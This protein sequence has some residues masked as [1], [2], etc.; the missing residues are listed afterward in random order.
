MKKLM[1]TFALMAVAALGLSACT[2]EKLVPD[3]G[4]ADGK[5]VTVHFGAE[6]AIEGATKATLTTE[7]EKTFKS[8]WE[9][10]DALS[11]EYSND[12]TPVNKGIV[13]ATWTADHFDATLPEHHGMWDYNVVYPAP[14]AESKVDFGSARTQK[15]NA[16]NSK[17]D[18]MKGSAIVENADAGKTDAGKNIVFNMTRQTAI[19]YFHLTSTL[20]EEVV[21]AKLS[22]EGGNIA[23]SL[24]MLLDHT[25]GFDL[26]TEDLNEITITFEEGTAPMASNFQLWFNVLPTAYTSMSLVVETTGHTLTLN[27]SNHGTFAAQNL[28]KVKGDVSSKW[29]EIPSVSFFYESFDSC[30]GTGGND[31]KWSGQIAT[32][33]I[34]TDNTGWTFTKENG[35]NACAKFGSG[36]KLGKATTPALGINTSSAT[37]SFKAGAWNGT[38]EVTKINIT[39]NNGGTVSPSSITLVKGQWTEYV[40]NITGATEQTTITFSASTDSKNRFFLDE[41][42]VYYGKKPFVKHVQQ[43]SFDKTSLECFVDDVTITEPK[44]S[45]AKTVVTY[46]SSDEKVA[47]VDVASGKVTILTAGNADIIATAEESEEYKSATAK[48][49]LKVNKHNQALSFEKSNYSILIADKDTFVSP[50]VSGAKTAVS[51]TIAL[52]EGTAKDAI[53]IDPKTGK[54]TINAVGEATIT[55]TAEETAVYTSAVAKYYLNV[56]ETASGVAAVEIDLSAQNFTDQK[57]IKTVSSSPITLTFDKGTN[58]NA[59]KYYTNGTAVRVYGGNTMTVSSSKTIV[60]VEI[61]FGESDGTNE[62]STNIGTYNV[63]TWTGESTNV[64]FTVATGKGNRRIQK[65]KV[66]Y[67][68]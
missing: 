31:G 5:F 28:Y 54:V 38:D 36:S 57:E 47:T 22:V 20:D 3:N 51:Y 55:A 39:A 52:G 66:T 23:S 11:V 37:L 4:N 26:S 33:T 49:S 67:N 43:I 48:Y 30:N 18:L 46:S 14:D 53:T 21:S 44:L 50:V 42:M 19:A 29:V 13:P 12:N 40:C 2:G 63:G 64:N 56:T 17:Y 25:D 35:A 41:V 27:N 6:A 45:G 7:D 9:N 24:V 58:T 32:N 34:A 8:A 68:Q 16:Y 60:K 10:G 65:V 1:K 61:T 15:G 59:P 62:I